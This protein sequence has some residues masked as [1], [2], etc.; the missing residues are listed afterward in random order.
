MNN[1]RGVSGE[2][3]ESHSVTIQWCSR[4]Q[5]KTMVLTGSF[6]PLFEKAAASG[7][8]SG[9]W[10]LDSLCHHYPCHVSFRSESC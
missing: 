4:D 2:R 1:N 6:L 7:V 3:R 8:G 9:D 10:R 5:S